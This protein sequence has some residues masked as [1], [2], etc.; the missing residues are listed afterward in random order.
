[1]DKE[2]FNRAVRGVF[3]TEKT[4]NGIGTYSEST[5]HAV[6]KNYYEPDPERHELEVGK[7]V[8]DIV[9]EDG[10]I[11]IQTRQLFR[12]KEKLRDFLS[13]SA[14]TVVCPVVKEKN[15]VWRNTDTGEIIGKRKSPKHESIYTAMTELYSLRE[16]IKEQNFRFVVPV[17]TADDYKDFRIGKN[18]RKTEVRRFDR[19]PSEIIAEETF[20][21]VANGDVLKLRSPSY[22]PSGVNFD[23]AVEITAPGAELR[24]YQ[25]SKSVSG[26]YPP[27]YGK[28]GGSEV[29]HVR[30]G[31]DG[32]QDGSNWEHAYP[33]LR[34]AFASAPDAS[35]TEV[36]LAVTNDY[37]QTAV[38]LAYPL[39]V[40]GGFAG[41]EDSPAERPEGSMTWLDG[42][43]AY[44]TM[45]FDVPFENWKE[46]IIG[47][48]ASLAA[49]RQ[50]ER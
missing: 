6:L 28:G 18:G 15:V 14:V 7:Y 5:L 23:V 37:M 3:E 46:A 34:A 17:I 8:A 47:T 24:N 22:Q 1:M 33:N 11:E 12:L 50:S 35:K 27:Y 38:A 41:V 30:T 13:V 44:K 42:S 31:A 36:W 20:A 48:G 39:T 4:R 21:R 9:G 29:I 45:D 2:N 10:I 43:S 40:R 19:V 16:F 25:E 26:T 32:M 49:A